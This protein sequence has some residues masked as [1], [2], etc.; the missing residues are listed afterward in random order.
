MAADI[1]SIAYGRLLHL[2]I[3]MAR[4]SDDMFRSRRDTVDRAEVDAYFKEVEKQEASEIGAEAPD[5]SLFLLTKAFRMGNLKGQV[6]EEEMLDL[7]EDIIVRTQVLLKPYIDAGTT[8]PQATMLYLSTPAISNHI[9][10]SSLPV[11]RKNDFF[12]LIER[13]F[14]LESL[15]VYNF[16]TVEEATQAI[17]KL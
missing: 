14:R 13:A 8:P 9:Y 16:A 5:C 2:K 7:A 1:K 12:G 3:Y 15:R 17:L 6:P 11:A 4:R 10:L